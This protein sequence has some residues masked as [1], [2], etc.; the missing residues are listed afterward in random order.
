ML[1]RTL[2]SPVG[3]S[4]L[5]KGMN[6]GYNVTWVSTDLDANGNASNVAG[7]ARYGRIM[8][9][10]FEVPLDT[11]G[12]PGAPLPAGI[13]GIAGLGSDVAVWI[14]ADTGVGVIGRDV[15]TAS[16]HTFETG[17][18]WI[19]QDGAGGERVAGRVYDD[20]G[21]VAPVADFADIS[22]PF[23]VAAGTTAK[24]VSAAAVNFGVVWV[25]QNARW[26]PGGDGQVLLVPRHRDQRPGLLTRRVRHV[27]AVQAATGR[28]CRR[29]QPPGHWHQRRGQPGS[30]RQLE[31]AERHRC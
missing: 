3:G 11:L 10:R 29:P 24:I 16:L 9:Q 26:Q 20:L 21:Q 8:M 31:A 2:A 6:D 25:T 1:D 18:I 12:N 7:D 5:P 22:G 27:R 17:V 30:D 19:E 23:S 13:D 28:Q 15:S 4:V 14:G